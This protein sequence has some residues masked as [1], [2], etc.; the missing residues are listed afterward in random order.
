MGTELSLAGKTSHM[1]S[2]SLGTSR[3]RLLLTEI[4]NLLAVD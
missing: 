4:A 2:I 3:S 1:P